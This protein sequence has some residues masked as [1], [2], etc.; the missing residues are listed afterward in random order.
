MRW[1]Y[2]YDEGVDPDDP[3]VREIAEDALREARSEAGLDQLP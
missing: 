2:E 3:V 1:F